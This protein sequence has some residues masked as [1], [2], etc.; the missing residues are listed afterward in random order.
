MIKIGL[1]GGIG[2][3]KTV[4]AN[5][6]LDL[7][8]AVYF[9]DNEAKKLM[10]NSKIIRKKIIKEFG[11]TSFEKGV[12]NRT[13]LASIVFN[14]SDKLKRLNA[15][16]HPEVEK[17]FEKWVKKQTSLYIIQEN[18]ILFENNSVSKFDYII[19]VTAPIDLRIKRVITRD[20]TT[21]KQVL[22][23]IN[24][25]SDDKKKVELSTFVIHNIEL[26]DT[27]QQVKEIHK[28]ICAYLK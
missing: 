12:L 13:Y 9:A 4:V 6:F 23:R 11:K 24:N 26:K 18:A 19:T 10:N 22:S 16:V 1:T 28:K 8:I 14:D 15:I 20:Q 3:G 21:K 7:G 5:C 17:H 25:Q 2:S 27:E